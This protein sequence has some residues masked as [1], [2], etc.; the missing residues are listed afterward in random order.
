MTPGLGILYVDGRNTNELHSVHPRDT[1]SHLREQYW[2]KQAGVRVVVGR[3]PGPL[4]WS[5][6]YKIL[7][8]DL[9]RTTNCPGDA[10][11]VWV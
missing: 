11:S 1:A 4:S 8:L 10:F 7:R 3:N 6:H 5:M 2:L 9:G